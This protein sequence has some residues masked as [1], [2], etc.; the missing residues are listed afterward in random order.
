MC[1]ERQTERSPSL[2]VY[3]PLLYALFY[4]SLHFL[5]VI[6]TQHIQLSTHVSKKLKASS[7]ESITFNEIAFDT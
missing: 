6:K 7:L 1:M 3:G 4:A 5:N 2:A